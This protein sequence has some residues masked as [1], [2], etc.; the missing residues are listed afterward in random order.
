MAK[1]NNADV[2]KKYQIGGKTYIQ[3]KLVLGQVRQLVEHLDG[4][5]FPADLNF[6]FPG[7]ITVLGDKLPIALAICLT[8]EGKS[9]RDKDIAALAGELD[10]SID[11]KTSLQA[12]KD[13]FFL[14]PTSLIL[15]S[16]KGMIEGL[17]KKTADLETGLKK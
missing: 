17:T 12:V 13:F 8:E 11:V 15:E 9:P 5:S 7:L 2:V 14:N 6:D 16:L 3:K 1:A 10:F 4:I